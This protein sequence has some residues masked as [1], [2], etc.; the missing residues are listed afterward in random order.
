M[1]DPRIILQQ[2]QGFVPAPNTL[3]DSQEI[4]AEGLRQRI[5]AQKAKDEARAA[6]DTSAQSQYNLGEQRHLSE[7]VNPIRDRE[8][9]DSQNP[10]PSQ[11]GQAQPQG[12]P[13][14]PPQYGPQQAPQQPFMLGQGAPNLPPQYQQAQAQQPQDAFSGQ[15]SV[16]DERAKMLADEK[17]KSMLYATVPV[18]AANEKLR[19]S[20]LAGRGD[21]AGDQY[22]LAQ[23]RAWSQ[24]A[25]DLESV[26][27]QGIAEM[28]GA[29]TNKSI[30]AYNKMIGG[31]QSAVVRA[32]PQL[33]NSKGYQDYMKDL[34]KFKPTP[35]P[36]M[37]VMMGAPIP[38]TAMDSAAKRIANRESTVSEE[39]AKGFNRRPDAF[40]LHDQLVNQVKQFDPNFTEQDTE[41][42]AAFAKAPATRR[43][44]AAIDNARTT[45]ARIM[46]LAKTN[47]GTPSP[48][49]NALINKFK[50]QAGDVDAAKVAIGQ[51]AG[52]EEY[53][54]AFNRNGGGSETTRGWADEL[55]G[56]IY[57]QPEQ[58]QASS[59]E[60][61]RAFDR[62]RQ[63]LM[64]QGGG[65]I[66]KPDYKFL[67]DNG[68]G[69]YPDAV[70]NQSKAY[71]AL[72]TAQQDPKI[73]AHARKVLGQ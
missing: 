22:S 17:R 57:Q 5:A 20:N 16:L 9:Q 47:A 54:G 3:Q 66:K 24:L 21:L 27:N 63:A 43:Y 12:Q 48:A 39:M 36:S 34:E 62:N 11:N 40:Q 46:E 42:G 64:K 45:A 23:N 26:K 8:I 72:P 71:L 31:I 38:A 7:L 67:D 51:L 18:L 4:Q 14:L 49:L 6:Q 2:A 56:L 33:L 70:I 30:D 15:Q 73:A 32:N 10:Q 68:Q 65:Y 61:L 35:Q 29:N 19:E 25:P 53:S 1:Y 52:T 37:A 50:V 41:S 58:A 13:N 60:L 59:T 69:K 55:G 44:V 28:R